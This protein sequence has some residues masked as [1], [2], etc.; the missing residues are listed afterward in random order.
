[1]EVFNHLIF[2]HLPLYVLV[3]VLQK[4]NQRCYPSL[5]NSKWHAGN[6]SEQAYIAPAR[7]FH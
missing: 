3:P 6:L 7:Q 1:M 2:V 5:S 4:K